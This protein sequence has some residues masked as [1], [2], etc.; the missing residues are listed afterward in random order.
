MTPIDYFMLLREYRR[1]TTLL[2][3]APWDEKLLQQFANQEDAILRLLLRESGPSPVSITIKDTTGKW[4]QWDDLMRGV[5]SNAKTA[6][7]IKHAA[8]QQFAKKGEWVRFLSENGYDSELTQARRYFQK[9]QLMQVQDVRIGD[10]HSH[11]F[12][13][14]IH[15]GGFNTVMFE[16]VDTFADKGPVRAPD[17]IN[18]QMLDALR[19]AKQ[20][21]ENGIEFGYITMP[22]GTGA[23]VNTLPAIDDAIRSATTAEGK[24]DV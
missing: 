21:I 13:K 3:R 8:P 5:A 6:T 20:F 19:K 2:T 18:A 24:S 23:A 22:K 12:F 16:R 14:G 15:S 4:G 11:Y 17:T 10:W 1:I 9:G 7:E